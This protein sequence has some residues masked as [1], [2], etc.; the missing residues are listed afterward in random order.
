MDNLSLPF[1]LL[2]TLGLGAAIGLEREAHENEQKNNTGFLGIRTFS[3]ITFLGGICG[4]LMNQHLGLF[5]I[6]SATCML[7]LIAYYVLNAWYTKDIGLT[8]EIAVIFSYLIGIVTTAA[9][10][11]IH[12][13]VALTVVIILILSRKKNIKE[14]VG[15]VS[16]HELNAFI[17]Y[18]L[19]ALVILPFLPNQSFQI[20][21]IP[22][23]ESFLKPFSISIE[24]FAAVELINPFKLWVVVAL[25][26]GIDLAGYVLE[27]TLG[28]SRGWLLASLV[29]GLISS[30]A[31]TQ[32]LAQQS[33]S[34]KSPRQLVGA[35]VLANMISFVP[36]FILIATLN[37]TFLPQ[38]IL[39]F[40]S[41]SLTGLIIGIFFLRSKKEKKVL[42]TSRKH[43]K[44]KQ[45]EIFSLSPAL[46]F[47]GIF[48]IIKIIS[49]ISLAIFGNE[50]L[51]ITSA[52]ASTTGMD[53][54]TIT[55]TDLVGQSINPQ[56]GLFAFVFANSVNLVSK[57]VYS[58][59][60]G[61]RQFATL[62]T[63]SMM[64]IIVVGLL[65]LLFI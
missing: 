15:G 23:I 31:T 7:L 2:I 9:I 61:S 36:L 14:F 25:I 33:I 20:G 62:F 16:R 29:G 18:G 58:F 37:S 46:K 54:I 57:S 26:T 38:V 49:K 42:H 32:S 5:L 30:T 12:L 35:A 10:L 21:H 39:F 40:G 6:I 44:Q 52:I 56:V 53:A 47:A 8:T 64:A 28:K 55:I 50:G 65:S 1:Q 13:I 48:L 59:M 11:P 63:R 43:I 22:H 34:T 3:L 19:L 24:K 51:F 60:Q 4:V 45:T 17:S 27:Q 41:I